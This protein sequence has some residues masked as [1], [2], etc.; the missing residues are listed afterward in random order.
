MNQKT[1]KK[2]INRSE[3]NRKSKNKRISIKSKKGKDNLQS[4]TVKKRGS[5]NKVQKTQRRKRS[6][7]NSLKTSSFIFQQA[8]GGHV[9]KIEKGKLRIIPLGGQEEVGRNMTVFEY[10]DDI[11]IVDMGMQFPEEDM[12]GI[13]YIVPNI[14]YLKGKEKNILGVVF[15]HGHLD[16]IGAA[17]ILLEQLGYPPIIGRDL[18][19]A[20][21]KRKLEDHEP[22]SSQR[23]K[24]ITVKSFTDRIRL[25]NFQLKFFEVEHSIM[26]SMGVVLFTPAV[27]AIHMGDWTLDVGS[28]SEGALSY[29]FLSQLP[30]P[31]VLMM[32][33]LGATSKRSLITEKEMWK[34]L[35]SLIDEAPGRLIIA[36]FST[37]VKRIRDILEYAKQTGKKVA[38]DG[39]SMKAN[40][41]V[42]K[43]LGYIK[44]DKDTLI[45]IKDIHKYPDKKVIVI[46]TGAQGEVNAVLSR[47]VTDNH[48]YIHLKKS[49]TIIFSSS[50]IPGNERSIQRLK[51]NLYRKCDNVIHSEIMDVHV[52]GHNNIE[53]IQTLV[54]QVK[55]TY[56]MPVYANHY[57]LKEAEK[58]IKKIGFPGRNIFILDNG[59]VIEFSKN[60]SPQILKEKADTSYVFIDGLGVGDIG[61]VVLRD[62]QMLSQDGMFVITVIIDSKTK[63]IVGNIQVT[64]RGFIY[65]KENFDLV[66]ATKQVVKKVVKNNTSGDSEIKI[67]WKNIET[68]IREE[69]GKYLFQKTQR[70]PMVLP[71]VMEV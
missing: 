26:D 29:E 19:L 59:Q 11:V 25:G 10:E 65:V 16:H 44:V 12:L 70:R 48:R 71:V 37:Q 28:S 69:V 36:T 27:T 9:K 4:K 56:V 47:I 30:Q 53:A 64:S 8:A 33:S 38:L 51:D 5:N 21:V 22:D 40:I 32:E 20:L 57:F 39:F 7:D 41:E 31:T 1:K 52:G 46:C 58:I 62:R 61:Q 67:N 24:T 45:D 13:D 35:R 14:N 34:N 2:R 42:A 23:V 49:D 60:R 54:K 43:Q 6:L 63:E 68:Q 50:V 18:T 17:P 15:T 66:N 3:N 55:P